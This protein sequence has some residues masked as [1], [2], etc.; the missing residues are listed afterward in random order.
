MVTAV[1]G[2]PNSTLPTNQDDDVS[3]TCDVRTL[4][5]VT[6]VTWQ[7]GDVQVAQCDA[8]FKLGNATTWDC[9]S[10]DPRFSVRKEDTK[11]VLN[12]ARFDVTQDKGRWGCVVIPLLSE[13]SAACILG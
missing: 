1:C 9:S 3:V 11:F 2:D 4:T 8:T 12:I 7:R 10:S 6:S 13:T 5:G